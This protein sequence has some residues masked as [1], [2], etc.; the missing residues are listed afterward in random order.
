[1]VTGTQS[2]IVGGDDRE[3]RH[4]AELYASDQQVRDAV[5]LEEITA[6]IR[7]P[8]TPITRLVATVMEG[9]ADR[10]ALGERATELVT[11]PATGRTSL[12]LLPRFDTVS[13][14]QLWARAGAV[15]AEWHHDSRHP[16]S[17]GEFVGVLGFTSGDYTTIDLACVRLGAVPVPLQASASGRPA[18]A[19]HRGDRAAHPRVEPGTPGHRR[20]MRA[21][22][23]VAAAP[24]RL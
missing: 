16:L 14:G 8:G 2:E 11:D 20:R 23:R 5:P 15:A 19:G 24:A 21:G 7:Q 6:A 9:Y 1:M 18:L 4:A 22:R 10:P 13:Y 3:E 12:R 17:A